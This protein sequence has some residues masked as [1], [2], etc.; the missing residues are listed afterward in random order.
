MAEKSKPIR[1]IESAERNKLGYSRTRITVKTKSGNNIERWYFLLQKTYIMSIPSQEKHLLW[2]I[3][4]HIIRLKTAIM[5]PQ[6]NRGSFTTQNRLFYRAKEPVLI[7]R[8]VEIF[9]SMGI[10]ESWFPHDAK[11][12]RRHGRG[13]LHPGSI[14]FL[15]FLCVRSPVYLNFMPKFHIIKL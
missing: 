15:W 10:I 6:C 8:G 14:G 2:R 5:L 12:L 4:R 11:C 13:C 9:W 7:Y 3:S 1:N